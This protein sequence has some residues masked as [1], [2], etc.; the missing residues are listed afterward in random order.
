MKLV[1]ENSTNTK[2]I[3]NPMNA[4][5]ISHNYIRKDEI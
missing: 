3:I 5:D 1:Y 4:V 2:T